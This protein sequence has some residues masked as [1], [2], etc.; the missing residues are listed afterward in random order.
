MHFSLGSV[1]AGVFRIAGGRTSRR[2][3]AI[4]AVDV[5]A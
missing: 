1:D 4:I 3:F 5:Q 2:S